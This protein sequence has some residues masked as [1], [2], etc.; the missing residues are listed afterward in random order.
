[1]DEVVFQNHRICACYLQLQFRFTNFRLRPLIYLSIASAIVKHN[2]EQ[3]THHTS[4]SE[5][6]VSRVIRKVFLA[7]EQAEGV[8]ATVRRSIGT[9]Q[10]RNFSPFLMLDHFSVKPP[11]GFPDQYVN[12]KPS[13]P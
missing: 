11:A 3:T 12:P 8:G 9:P 5:M 7:R 10:L 13:M 4:A 1:M 6:A 2:L